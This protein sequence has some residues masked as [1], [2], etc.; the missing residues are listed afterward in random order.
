MWR[1]HCFP[2]QHRSPV[3]QAL[4]VA[5]EAG[6]LAHAILKMEQGI[7]GSEAQHVNEA[8]DA[9]GDIIIYLSGIA[10]SLGFDLETA[11]KTAWSEVASRDW[12]KH[13]ETGIED[14]RA[15]GGAGE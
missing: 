4:G 1:E 9:V 2:P 5:E 10:S 13:K 6:E 11:V 8:I 12:S 15:S 14:A 7:R 3:M